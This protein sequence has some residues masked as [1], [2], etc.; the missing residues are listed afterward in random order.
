[1]DYRTFGTVTFWPIFHYR[2]EFAAVVRAALLADPPEVVAVELP[3]PWRDPILQGVNRLPFLS[4]VLGEAGDSHLF[5]P[6]EPCDG[7]MEA[8]R[9]AKELGLPVEL[10]D[11][12]VDEYPFH[13]DS[14]PDSFSLHRLGYDPLLQAYYAHSGA[15]PHPLDE[16]RETMMAH[17]LQQLSR[18]GRRVACV[19]GAAHLP[20]LMEK[21]RTSQPR[22]LAR[23]G[24]RK[25]RLFNWSR[26]SSREFMSEAPFLSAA[27]ERLRGGQPRRGA[28]APPEGKASPEPSPLDREAE[29][30][31][32]LRHAAANYQ[33]RYKE[34]I[35]VPQRN[36]LANFAKKYALVDGMIVPDLYHL[37]VASRGVA[38][39]DFAYEVWELGS[40]YPWQ[41]GSGMLPT[42]DLD[43]EYAYL[44]GRRLTL[45]RKIRRNRP[46]LARFSAKK[47]LREHFAG[48]WKSRWS[49]NVICSHQP[50]D[51]IIEDYGRYLKHKAKGLLS[52]ERTRV[53]PFQVSLKDGIDVRET[54]RNWNENTLYVRDV[55]PLAGDMG[56]VVVIFDE[57]M[58]GQGTAEGSLALARENFPWLVTWHGENAQESDMAL[59]ATPAGEELVGP[60]ISR[61]EYGGFLLSYPPRRMLDVWHDPYFDPARTKA[62]RLLMAGID[63]SVERH[64]LYIAKKA[65]R[66][67]FNSIAERMGRKVIYLP[68]GQL[69]PNTVAKIRTFHVLEGHHVREYAGDYIDM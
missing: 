60:G 5:L 2:L 15:A 10:I 17:A 16:Q 64:V 23:A 52:A 37:V 49:G 42:I 41:D 33:E 8:I 62:E 19:L 9:T 44:A 6:I 69:S 3:G 30:E 43:E 18:D 38:G 65:P 11:L 32:L 31:A 56:S 22:P 67:W 58:P 63:Y 14:L 26:R 50:E 4:L 25:L 45:R 29:S 21:L 13:Q 59:Y 12:D 1:M 20:G 66:S 55:M 35:G 36:A 48:E 34:E 51:L 53:E 46:R 54:L 68:L 27:Y 61:C 47:R 40:E 7:A 24:Q 28:G 39:D 57:D